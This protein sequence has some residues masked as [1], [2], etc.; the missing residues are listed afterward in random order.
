MI[1]TINYYKTWW[2]HYE[3][4]GV[5]FGKVYEI[6]NLSG[7]SGEKAMETAVM[8]AAAVSGIYALYFIITY[9]IACDH[10]VCCGSENR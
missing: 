10:V 6:W 8:I 9:R 4:M 5:I 3:H 1:E 7:L 2:N